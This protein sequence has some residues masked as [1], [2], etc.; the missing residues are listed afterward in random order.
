MFHREKQIHTKN[1][2]NF[3]PHVLDLVS[4]HKTHPHGED[5]APPENSIWIWLEIPTKLSICLAGLDMG[6]DVFDCH[7]HHIS[8][9]FLPGCFRLVVSELVED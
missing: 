3:T 2:S 6:H 5:I 4:L 8:L 7:I 9:V 1:P